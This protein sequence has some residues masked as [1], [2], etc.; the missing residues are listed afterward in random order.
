MATVLDK[1]GQG[2]VNFSKHV[3]D[4][5]GGGDDANS[6]SRSG[7]QGPSGSK[8]QT[9]LEAY[10]IIMRNNTLRANPWGRDFYYSKALIDAEYMVE[11]EYEVTTVSSEVTDSDKV[12]SFDIWKANKEKDIE[13]LRNQIDKLNDKASQAKASADALYNKNNGYME[14]G[15]KE[16]NKYQ[17]YGEKYNSYTA[18]SKKKQN[19]LKKAQEELSKGYTTK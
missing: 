14:Q 5:V 9:C 1:I 8:G 13:R 4:V 3:E 2:I 18:R 7:Y 17:S 16:L 15:S 11:S 6:T 10:G 12:E 19:E